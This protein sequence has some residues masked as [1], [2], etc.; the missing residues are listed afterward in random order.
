M[1]LKK[2]KTSVPKFRPGAGW[3]RSTPPAAPKKKSA[4]KRKPAKKARKR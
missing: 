1:A 3:K 2:K 4:S